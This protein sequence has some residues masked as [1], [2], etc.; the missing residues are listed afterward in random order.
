MEI[1]N[2][3]IWSQTYDCDMVEKYSITKLYSQREKDFF[4][5]EKGQYWDLS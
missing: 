4:E 2:R 5:E 3:Y 1:F